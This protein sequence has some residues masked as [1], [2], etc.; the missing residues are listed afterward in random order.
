MNL[1]DVIDS[2]VGVFFD[3]DEFGKPVIYNGQNITA[4]VEIG[5]GS[6]TKTNPNDRQKNYEDAIFGIKIADV[7]SPSVGDTLIYN[8]IEYQY[9]STVETGLTRI[10]IR[11]IAGG[12]AVLFGGM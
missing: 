5:E 10:R 2:D 9:V 7:A 1:K 3:T 8:G 4:L 11:C 12:S 6:S